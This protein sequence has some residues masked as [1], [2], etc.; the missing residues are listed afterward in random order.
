M[1]QYGGHQ[2][3]HGVQ[4]FEIGPESI[5]IEFGSGWVYHFTYVKPGPMRVEHMKQL[6]E[7]GQ[8]LTTFINKHVRN[9]YESRRRKDME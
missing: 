7:S 9:R 8:G 5:D 3:K 1:R 4:A 6:A 2:K